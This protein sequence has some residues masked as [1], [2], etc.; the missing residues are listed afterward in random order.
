ML[1][2]I[3][4][5]AVV[6]D[7]VF[8]TATA[9]VFTSHF[10][11][12]CVDFLYTSFCECL[13]IALINAVWCIYFVTDTKQCSAVVFAHT[14]SILNM[15]YTQQYVIY[16]TDMVQKQS[17]H[18]HCTV[19]ISHAICIRYTNENRTSASHRIFHPHKFNTEE[20]IQ[21]TKKYAIPFDLYTLAIYVCLHS[22]YEYFYDYWK[23]TLMKS[24]LVHL[25]VCILNENRE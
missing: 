5:S 4:V 2:K 21:W 17:K 3:I 6:V 8:V 10:W 20:D 9:F 14:I 22:K 23:E 24:I 11:N 15:F 18:A 7:V 13:P 12:S 19:Q 16:Q 1:H 25:I